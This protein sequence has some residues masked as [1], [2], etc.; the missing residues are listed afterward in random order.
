[1]SE[2]MKIA[3][4]FPGQASQEVGMGIGLKEKYPFAAELFAKANDVLGYDIARLIES[5]PIEDLTKTENAQPAILLVSYAAYRALREEGI[6]GP[7]Y[8][9]GHS[10][11]EY[12]ALCAADAVSF[13]DAMRLV[14]LRGKFMQQACPLGEGAM[15]AV[16]GLTGFQAGVLIDKARDGKIIDLANYNA[17]NQIV[18]SGSKSAIEKACEIA[19]GIG[20]KRCVMLNVSA[21]FHSSLMAPAVKRF[22]SE[23]EKVHFSEPAK[24]V[25]A[26]YSAL[27]YGGIDSIRG[28]LAKQIDHPVLYHQSVKYLLDEGIDAVI[29]VGPGKVLTGLNKRIVPSE[30]KVILASFGHP[31]DLASLKSSLS[32]GEAFAG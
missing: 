1:M 15:A 4:V 21:P 10:L 18:I 2:T 12:T 5:G 28:L 32:G 24:P 3:Y 26:N 11:G 22:A 16:M 31:D 29:E 27:P 17:P 19:P 30:P 23:L 14:H 25:I 20:A 13:E 9:I 7:D 8:L 6:P